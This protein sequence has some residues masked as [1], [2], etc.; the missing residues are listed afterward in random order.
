[1]IELVASIVGGLG[2]FAV[3]MWLLTENLKQAASRRLRR[4]AQRLAGHPSTAF[5]WGVLAGGATQSTTALVFIVVSLL[6]SGLITTKSAFALVLGGGGGATLLVMFVTFDIWT[7]S[8]FV[9]GIAGMAVASEALSKYRWL[10]A[11][12]LGGAMIILGLTLLKDAAAPLSQEPWFREMLEGTGGSPFLAFLVAA[13]LTASVQSSGAVSVFAIS[14]AAVGILTVDQVIM[15]V[16]GTFVGASAVTYMLSTNLTGRSRQV[17]M[18][19]VYWNVVICAITIPLF[20]A[21]LY[22]GIPSVKALVLS[23][24]L[25]LDQQLALVYLIGTIGLVPVMLLL[26]GPT[27]ALYEK[28]WPVSPIEELSKTQFIGNHSHMDVDTSMML[29]ELEQKRAFGLLS[30]YFDAVRQDTEIR[31]IRDASRNVLSEVTL[32]LDE[33]YEFLPM[34]DVESRN[35]AM[36]RQKLLWWMENAVG[37]M[38]AALLNLDARQGLERFSS[39]ICEGV[40]AVFLAIGDAMATDDEVS[41]TTAARI[42]GDRSALMRKMRA[43]YVEVD[44]PLLKSDALNV[45]LVTNIVEETFFLMSKIEDEFN[46]YS[47]AEV[48]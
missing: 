47:Q 21:E 17:A 25:G 14:L 33:L 40:D 18:Y 3:G 4:I 1:M 20:Y 37:T 32:F 29:V 12:F 46:P 8:L 13:A 30:R 15:C 48:H 36:S 6:R 5:C 42:I 11:S 27:V 39:E 41:W 10:A 2:L 28:L 22:L 38:C 9:L 34:Q 7:L 24:P 43:A 23:F 35:A 44:L 16:Y 45:L 31:P 26:L 19:L